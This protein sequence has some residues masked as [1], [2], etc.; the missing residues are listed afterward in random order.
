MGRGGEAVWEDRCE[1]HGGGIG[2]AGGSVMGEW[3]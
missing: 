1:L 2:M 3:R